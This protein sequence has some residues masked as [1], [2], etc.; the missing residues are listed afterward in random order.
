MNGS[1]K[2][3][4]LSGLVA[5][6]TAVLVVPGVATSRQ[7]P[8]PTNF[9]G[10]PFLPVNINPT[11]VPPMVNISPN[12]RTPEVDIRRI[13]AVNVSRLPEVTV[14]PNG[15]EDP[16]NFLTDIG[17]AIQGPFLVT[18]LNLN[19]GIQTSFSNG[20][21]GGNVEVDLTP[22]A[23]L[24]TGLYLGSGQVLT[25]SDAILYSGCNPRR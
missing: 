20:S 12:G 13:P 3:L 11:N 18:Y 8:P 2:S 24:A 6:V 25:F 10:T 22:D 21:G 16:V 23:P 4:L 19:E 7:S 15:C 5:C 1:M 14:T 9:E 17:S